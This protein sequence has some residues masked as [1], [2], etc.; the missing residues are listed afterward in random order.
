[1]LDKAA[2]NLSQICLYI[3]N[4]PAVFLIDGQRRSHRAVAF[5]A[6]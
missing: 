5:I 1:M 4:T 2:K 6:H 3:F